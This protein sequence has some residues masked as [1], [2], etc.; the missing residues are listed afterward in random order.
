MVIVQVPKSG[1]QL[2]EFVLIIRNSTPRTLLLLADEE[3]MSPME[4]VITSDIFKDQ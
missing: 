1:N 2:S 3:R 4:L